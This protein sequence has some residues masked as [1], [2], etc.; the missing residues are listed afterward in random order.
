MFFIAFLLL[1]PTNVQGA[2][3]ITAPVPD[4][5]FSPTAAAA[6]DDVGG[7]MC[8]VTFQEM[9]GIA[10]ELISLETELFVLE[11]DYQLAVIEHFNLQ[12]SLGPEHPDTIDALLEVQ[13][14]AAEISR[15]ANE[16]EELQERYDE[17]KA[18]ADANCS[19]GNP[20]P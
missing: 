20:L 7:L 4:P 1:T 13:R 18:W 15:V 6:P 2:A 9:A 5:M 16:M 11:Q 3:A 8:A 14:L 19:E 17:L 10:A 12:R